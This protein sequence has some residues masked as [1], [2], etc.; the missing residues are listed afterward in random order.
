MAFWIAPHLFLPVLSFLISL[1]ELQTLP[2]LW[3][4]CDFLLS[5]SGPTLPLTP[6]FPGLTLLSF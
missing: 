2:G 5:G 1:W 6:S 4:G 3:C